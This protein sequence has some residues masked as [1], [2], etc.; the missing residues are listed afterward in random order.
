M[1]NDKR[2]KELLKDICLGRNNAMKSL[3]VEQHLQMNGNVLRRCV[4][5]LRSRGTP[6]CSSDEGYFFGATAGEVIMTIRRLD[7]MIDGLIRARNGMLASLDSF[8]MEEE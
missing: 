2:V 6:I 7:K 8:H 3:E 4:N 1:N 5:R